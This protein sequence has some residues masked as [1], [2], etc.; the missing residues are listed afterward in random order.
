MELR[1]AY[2]LMKLMKPEGG[3]ATVEALNVTENGIY[4]PDEGVDGFAPVNVNVPASAVDS[5]TKSIN[6]NGTH[7]VVGYANAQVSVPASAVVS[8]T[9][10]ITENGNYDVTD[11]AGANVNVSGGGDTELYESIIDGTIS[12]SV[13]LNVNGLGSGAL[14]TRH[15]EALNLPNATY[16]NTS[17]LYYCQSLTAVSMPSVSQVGNSAFCSCSKLQNVYAPELT[18]VGA[19]AFAYCSSLASIVLSSNPVLNNAAFAYCKSLS[20][21]PALSTMT[22]IGVNAFTG[23][24]LSS[25]NCPNVEYIGNSAFSNC[26]ELLYASFPKYQSTLIDTFYSCS[27]L[28]SVYIPLVS[29]MSQAFRGCR[30]L[31][32]LRF[33]SVN[34]IG[35]FT[36]YDCRSLSALYI[37]DVNVPSLQNVNAFNSTPM[38]V[39]TYIG[40]FGS[41]YVRASLLESYKTAAIWSVYSARMVGLTDEE[42]AALPN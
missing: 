14:M 4:T 34:R 7:D 11:Y 2:L 22:S 26:S 13:V 36:F 28:T 12:G 40:T 5:G 21:F 16:I 8:G 6:T 1:E 38:S 10:N 41:I 30:S 23:T 24:A 37:F 39:S 29:S 27:K 17:A 15:I 18:S 20:I 9:L 19:S 3:G 31:A 35:N 33:D 25:V 42:I 32:S